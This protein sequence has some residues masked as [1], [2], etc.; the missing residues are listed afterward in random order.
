MFKESE[1]LKQLSRNPKF[2]TI[3][4]FYIDSNN[5]K[6]ALKGDVNTY[7]NYPPAIVMEFMEGG[8]AKD[9]LTTSIIYST[10]WPLIVKEII[11]EIAYALDFLH[12][13]G[14]VHLDVKP[15]NI[16]FSRNLGNNPEE[17]YKNISSS[18]KLGDLGS[19]V[20]IGERFY[21]ATPSYSPPEQI[22][23]I[24]TGKGADPK[25]DIFAL[26]MTAYVLLTGKNDNPI[27]DNL[28]KAID[29]YMAGNVGEA[30]KLIQNAK[31]I[32]S[33]WR[34][35]LPQNTPS[36]LTRVIVYSI[37]INPLS[38]PSAKQIVDLLK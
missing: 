10:Y 18:I 28:N 6:S 32:L 15:E 2:V 38:R 24:I 20:R 35:I 30:L 27:S 33:S 25:M 16:F 1:T 19:A 12:S 8:T 7:Y 23:A 31:Q 36:E 34:P 4:G 17:I 14:F 37:N 5:I 21:Q 3:L 26:G 11:K 22:E 13:K 9:L 29:A